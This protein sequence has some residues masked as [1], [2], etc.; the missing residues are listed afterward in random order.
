MLTGPVLALATLLPALLAG[1][2]TGWGRR[3][4][5]AGLC[6]APSVAVAL[7]IIQFSGGNHQHMAGHVGQAVQYGLGF[8]LL[9]PAFL[10]LD[11]NWDTMW[12]AGGLK[13]AVVAGGLWLASPRLRRLLLLLLAYDLGNAAL[14][15]IGRYHTGFTTAISSRY[16]YSSL[17]ATLPFAALLLGAAVDRLA[18]RPRAR[19]F[20]ATMLLAALTWYC[21]RSWP[22]ELAGFA[23]ERGTELR[24]TMAAPA[25]PGSKA[26]VPALDF[27]HVERG[28]ALIR[29]YHLH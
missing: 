27:M 19:Q 13:L 10:L 16:Y 23:R 9:N 17:I 6:L 18:S 3:I 29:A 25:I 12:V 28:K 5:L 8:F 26:T 2:R 21:F 20:A 14:L 24:R 11:L 15:G 22:D 7:L 4:G 1:E